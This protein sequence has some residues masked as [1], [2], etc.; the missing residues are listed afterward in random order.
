M[1]AFTNDA[2]AAKALHQKFNELKSEIRDLKLYYI[3][4][5][6]SEKDI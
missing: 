3:L 6:D 2:E 5:D 1:L 4:H